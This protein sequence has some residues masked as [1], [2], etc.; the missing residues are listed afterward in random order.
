MSTSNG[1]ERRPA[2]ASGAPA[3]RARTPGWRDPRLWIGIALVAASVVAGARLL[4]TADDTVGVWAA[5]SDLRAGEQVETGD[6]QVHQ[7]REPLAEGGRYL[8]SDEPL[9]EDRRLGRAV[10]TGELV[11]RTA[12]GSAL[13]GVLEVPLTVPRGGVPPGVTAGSQ[14]DVWVARPDTAARRAA[15]VL[16]DAV[17][18]QAPPPDES[19]G[20][21]GERRLV[22]AVDDSEAASLGR[23]L[24]AAAAGTV[25]VVGRR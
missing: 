1:T 10:G 24:A 7:V 20:A 13:T 5:A 9:P 14:V 16:D 2:G 12:L 15:R 17:V 8:L 3:T 21:G 25:Y 23:A 4:G 18:V 11:P 22:L 6:L 19:F